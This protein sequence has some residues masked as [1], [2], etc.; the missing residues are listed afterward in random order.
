LFPAKKGE[1]SIREA[2]E[3]GLFLRR[4]VGISGFQFK[5]EQFEG[6]QFM[7]GL[8]NHERLAPRLWKVRQA[9]SAQ[10]ERLSPS[11]WPRYIGN[12]IYQTT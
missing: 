11:A 6:K 2:F 3:V 7:V 12:R 4:S 1:L 9:L 10:N 5:K 8:S